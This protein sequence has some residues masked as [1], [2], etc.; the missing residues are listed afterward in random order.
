MPLPK[1]NASASAG[2]GVARQDA[3]R[4][5][6]NELHP[7][8]VDTECSRGWAVR[9][10]GVQQGHPSVVVAGVDLDIH[11]RDRGRAATLLVARNA[12]RA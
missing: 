8:E 11:R 7:A 4:C 9:G 5:P 12:L 1:S 3:K 2:V 6:G 10:H